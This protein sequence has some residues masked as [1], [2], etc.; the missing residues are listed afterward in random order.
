VLALH[1][2]L[3]AAKPDAQS[4]DDAL[5]AEGHNDQLILQDGVVSATVDLTDE[6]G[7]PAGTSTF[8]GNTSRPP[9]RSS[10][11]VTRCE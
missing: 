8:E 7:D 4:A 1:A 2:T 6:I 10:G 9:V 11:V 5:L 3:Q